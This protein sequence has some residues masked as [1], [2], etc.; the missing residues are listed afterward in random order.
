[1]K[2]SVQTNLKKDSVQLMHNAIYEGLVWDIEINTLA[3]KQN[4]KCIQ[5]NR[6]ND[7]RDPSDRIK[8]I[9]VREK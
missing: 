6:K 5:N 9:L 4:Q 8:S 1:M 2:S 7:D 3:W